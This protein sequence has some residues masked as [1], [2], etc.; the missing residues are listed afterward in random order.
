MQALGPSSRG[1]GR[2]Q[3]AGL[4]ELKAALRVRQSRACAAPRQLDPRRAWFGESA[5]GAV[6]ASGASTIH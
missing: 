6:S 4:Q 1:D 2:G 5:I 3:W